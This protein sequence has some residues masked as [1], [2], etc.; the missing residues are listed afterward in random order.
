MLQLFLLFVPFISFL[1]LAA[2]L[3]AGVWLLLIGKWHITLG[4]VLIAFFGGHLAGLAMMPGMAIA[5]LFMTNTSRKS[6]LFLGSVVLAVYNFAVFGWWTWFVID[7]IFPA[8]IS[9]LTLP[10]VLATYSASTSPI[11]FLASHE[12]DNPF[13]TISTICFCIGVFA[14]LTGMYVFGATIKTGFIILGSLWALSVI[15]NTALLF[16]MDE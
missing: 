9:Q 12:R 4:L 16:E 13:S 1:N 2:G 15:L 6:S 14:M 7:S 10:I 5:G 11:R 3:I 8:R